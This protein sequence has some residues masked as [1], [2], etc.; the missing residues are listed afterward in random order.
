MFAFVADR[1]PVQ[2][3]TSLTM[4]PKPR[5]NFLSARYATRVRQE[6]LRSRCAASSR[7]IQGLGPVGSLSCLAGRVHAHATDGG[8]DAV[9]APFQLRCRSCLLYTSRCV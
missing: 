5:L 2:K 8:F 4:A 3:M 6:C 1:A 7:T 9:A